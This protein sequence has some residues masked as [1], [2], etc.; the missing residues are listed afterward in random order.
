[1]RPSRRRSTASPRAVAAFRAAGGKGL[2][3]TLPF[4]EEAF[5]LCDE[6]SERARVARAVNTLAFRERVFGDNTDG[7]GLV[8]DLAVNLGPIPGANA[9]S[10]WGRA[11]LRKA[12]SG[13]LLEAGA[14][15]TRHRQPHPPS[16]RPR[17]R[18]ASPA[19]GAVATKRC[20]NALRPRG[21]RDFRRP[22]GRRAAAA[23]RR[24]RS[25]RARLRHGVW[26]RYA[27]SCR[28]ARRRARAPATGWACWSSRR[29]SRSSS[30]AACGPQTAPVL[31]RAARVARRAGGAA[32]GVEDL[33]L[34]PGQPRRARRARVQLWFFAHIAVLELRQPRVHGVHGR[35][36]LEKPRRAGCA[37]P[38]SATS[39]S[40]RIS[41][42][43]WSPP[44][45]RSSSTTKASTGRRSRRR[46]RRTS[47][48][49]GWW[50]APRPSAS[51]WRRTC[52]FPAQ[53]SWVR[54]AQ[55]AVITW[56]IER[57]MSQAPHPRALPQLRRVGRGRVRR[58]SRGA[59]SLRRRA[60]PR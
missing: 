40:R 36:R 52:S 54:K 41:S 55:E 12:W 24:P 33:L 3:V 27:V 13:G 44:R 6:V 35:A 2:N 8:R 28:R 20:G 58:R 51:S 47:R 53:R 37:T 23:L 25:G 16:A 48:R 56:M 1:M 5:A 43:R 57:T 45:T 42:A 39:A 9:C 11:A 46:C 60:R 19:S 14:A 30:G 21:E 29:P 50:R 32:A 15:R 4:K 7:V 34:H 31:D 22:A 49:A 38:G 10:S 17:S 18:R 26:P 59:P